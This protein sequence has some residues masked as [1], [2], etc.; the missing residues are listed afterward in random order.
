MRLVRLSG[1]STLRRARALLL[2]LATLTVLIVVILGG[3]WGILPGSCTV[4]YGGTAVNIT[5]TGWGSGAACQSLESGRLSVEGT[6][7]QPGGGSNAEPMSQPF[8][9]L[10]CVDRMPVQ[11]GPTVGIQPVLGYNIEADGAHPDGFASFLGHVLGP[12]F[13][14]AQA[15]GTPSYIGLPWHG[16]VQVWV[17]DTGLRIAGQ[18]ACDELGH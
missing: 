7:A 15:V 12:F 14:P 11:A 16:T 2:I 6:T 5:A 9:D 13:Q 18:S 8:G 4:A 10:V 17:R 3:A 1:K